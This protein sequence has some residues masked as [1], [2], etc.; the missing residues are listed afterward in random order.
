V[1]PKQNVF[2]LR[3]IWACALIA[4][5]GQFAAIAENQSEV[6]SG[7]VYTNQRT[8]EPWSIHLVRVDRSKHQFEIR[9]IHANGKAIGLRPLSQQLRF[10]TS[11]MNRPVA[12]INGDFYRRDSAYAGDPRGLQISDGDTLSGPTGGGTFWMDAVGDPH[13]DE[14]A[15]EFQ[16]SFSNGTSIPFEVNEERYGAAV[17]YTSSFG[18]STGTSGGGLELLLEAEGTAPLTPLRIGRK[19]SARVT[20]VRNSG[21]SEIPAGQAVLSL[22]RILSRKL[23]GLAVGEKIEISTFCSP[24][25]RAVRTA[26]SGGPILIRDGKRQKLSGSESDSFQ[27][28]SMFE[29]HPRTALGWNQDY[30]FLVEVDGRQRSSAGMTLDEL[31]R[32]MAGLGCQNAMNFDGGGSATLWYLGKV[33]NSPCD[34]RERPIANSLVITLNGHGAEQKRADR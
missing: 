15:P 24:S 4:L 9:S 16:V 33:R 23:A 3:G 11:E 13:L 34:G 7:I 14:I 19:Y 12:A 20:A 17:V 8:R 31:A 22:P 6:P 32:Y 18:T 21:N 29:R 10:F 27:L 25:L 2:T 1:K 30:L 26:I 5:L 28:S